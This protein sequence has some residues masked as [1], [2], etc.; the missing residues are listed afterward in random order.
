M[1]YA[2]LF[3]YAFVSGLIT[4]YEDCVRCFYCGIGLKRWGPEDDVWE[5]HATWRGVCEYLRRVKGDTFVQNIW[6]RRDPALGR[7]EVDSILNRSGGGPNN[8]T[9]NGGS[10]GTCS[11]S[12]DAG[13]NN[14]TSGGGSSNNNGEDGNHGNQTK[15]R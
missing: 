10:T 3:R 4:G 5:T 6:A 13:G 7:T 2:G 11:G 12:S 1:Y 9:A 15:E 8:T 14:T